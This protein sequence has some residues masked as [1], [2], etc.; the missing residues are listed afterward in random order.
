MTAEAGAARHRD[1]HPPVCAA[2]GVVVPRRPADGLAPTRRARPPGPGAHRGTRRLGGCPHDFRAVHQGPRHENDFVL[3]PDLDGTRPLTTD[4]GAP[5]RGPPR[6]PRRRRRD[7]GRARPHAP[8]EAE[9]RAQARDAEWF[10]DYRNADGSLGRDVRQRL[11]RL[12]RVPAARGARRR[13]DAFRIATR[14]GVKTVRSPA[15]S[16]PSTSVR[17]GSSTRRAPR[18]DGFDV[19]V[20]PAATASR[21]PALSLDLGNPHAVVML[22]RDIDLPSL[23]LTE[24]PAVLAA[25]RRRHQRRVRPGRSD[26][27]TS[28]CGSTSAASAR[29]ARAAPA[30]PP[31]PSRPASGPA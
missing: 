6:R 31:P 20:R 4:A 23:D 1:G 13:Q 10:M 11:A 7:P 29:P 14:A 9:V 26:R 21:V 16:T 8:T 12:R 2:A 25:A 30:L 24:P 18:R 5:P 22:R 27:G 28:P 19:T 3:V 17:G 15:S